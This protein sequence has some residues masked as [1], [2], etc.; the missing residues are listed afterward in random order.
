MLKLK[1][2]EI[3][4]ESQQIKTKHNNLIT[5][6]TLITSKNTSSSSFSSNSNSSSNSSSSNLKKNN[7][8]KKK[9]LEDENNSNLNE[10]NEVNEI[11]QKC[12]DKILSYSKKESSVDL[13]IDFYS[14]YVKNLIQNENNFEININYLLKRS[15]SLDKVV[16][17]RSCQ[18]ISTIFNLITEDIEIDINLWDNISTRLLPRLCDKCPTVRIWAVNAL[19]DFQKPQES[20]DLII[21]EYLRLLESD[22]SKDVRLAVIECLCLCPN[23]LNS[24]LNR[25]RDVKSEVRMKV[26]EQLIKSVEAGHLTSKQIVLFVRHSLCD[27]DETISKYSFQL[28]IKWLNKLQYNIPKFLRLIG[29]NSYSNEAEYVSWRIL[30]ELQSSSSSSSALETLYSN[31]LISWN[32]LHFIELNSSEVLW[33]LSRSEYLQQNKNKLQSNEYIEKY[34]PDT[35]ILCRL[36]SEGI[37][38]LKVSYD[39]LENENNDTNNTNELSYRTHVIT[40]ELLLK[41]LIRL[42]HFVDLNDIVGCK[43]VIELCNGI[44]EDI[45]NGMETFIPSLTEIY[46]KMLKVTIEPKNMMKNMME[47]IDKLWPIN[48]TGLSLDIEENSDNSNLIEKEKE[49]KEDDA[50]EKEEENSELKEEKIFLSQYR[51]LQIMIEMIRD[52][53]RIMNQSSLSSSSTTTTTTS[54]NSVLWSFSSE[55]IISHILESLQM[56]YFELRLNSIKAVGLLCLLSKDL[57]E[58][59]Y[60]I[61]YQVVNTTQEDVLIRCEAVETLGDI[62]L[63]YGHESHLQNNLKD[64]LYSFKRILNHNHDSMLTNKCIAVCSKL[65]LS[66]SSI[67]ISMSIS[68]SP[69]LSPSSIILADILSQLIITFFNSHNEEVENDNENELESIILTDNEKSKINN[70]YLDQILSVFIQSYCTMGD[71][72]RYNLL[73]ESISYVIIEYSQRIR[74]EDVKMKL[75]LDKVYFLLL[76]YLLLITY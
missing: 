36:I 45:L 3:F 27:R 55:L 56:P 24:L 74:N 69:S 38:A 57:S 16:R 72:C 21:T 62:L 13:V 76:D 14:G 20:N 5:K 73:L 25:L 23:T 11:I 64:I 19:K 70:E 61:I 42:L 60:N 51:C 9:D 65:L 50:D 53:I 31:Y 48:T 37:V 47:L 58:K 34:L 49:K 6:L 33:I 63:I 41:Y 15:E 71:M 35:I 75:S 39:Y 26:I 22:P 66:S 12:Y 28:V 4:N 44:F 32:S 8:L 43:E 2:I 54:S 7:N 18:T 52:Q 10:V 30:Q 1:I 67:S 68:S 46:L 17:F 40:Y 59:Y 29:L